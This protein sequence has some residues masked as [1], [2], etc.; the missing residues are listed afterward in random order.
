MTATG[1]RRLVLTTGLF[2]LLAQWVW[3]DNSLGRAPSQTVH[4]TPTVF[5][6]IP[7]LARD[8]S[9]SPASATPSIPPAATPI[10]P[11][12]AN[13]EQS[14]I[15]RINGHREENGL[16]ALTLS[17]GLTQAA[18]RHGR[19]MADNN[20]TDHTGSDG[21]SGGE[22]MLKAGYDWVAW[23]EIIGWGFG[24][25]PALMVDWWLN[26]P[27]H[28]SLILSDSFEDLGAGYARNADS[29]WVHYWTVNFGRRSPFGSVAQQE[30]NMCTYSAEDALGGTTMIVYSVNPCAEQ[31]NSPGR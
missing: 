9:L 19:D 27:V 5:V 16:A 17:S 21:S 15:D 13:N 8:G 3:I 28:H 12:D 1:R 18:R 22:R 25:D 29:D 4:F 2:I 6:H 10:P 30:L 20:F 26:S 23:G 11:D 7:M 31:E 14:I 24:G